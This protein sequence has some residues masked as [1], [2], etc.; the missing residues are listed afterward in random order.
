M[1]YIID[2]L[3]GLEKEI[4]SLV[5]EQISIFT[6]FYRRL[7]IIRDFINTIQFLRC[8]RQQQNKI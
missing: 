4:I 3:I 7:F 2:W 5:L 6:F 1:N 8:W